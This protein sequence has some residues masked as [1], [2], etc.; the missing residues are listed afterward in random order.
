M[1]AVAAGTALREPAKTGLDQTQCLLWADTPGWV[2]VGSR[3]EAA[4][5]L[6]PSAETPVHYV[7]RVEAADRAS[8]PGTES[9]VATGLGRLGDHTHC[10]S[11][12]R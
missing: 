10:T 3:V 4:G 9:G 11:M 5:A 8:F 6:V 12:Q 1:V 2:R 7:A